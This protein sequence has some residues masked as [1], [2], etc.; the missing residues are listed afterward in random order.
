METLKFK[1]L[2]FGFKKQFLDRYNVDEILKE[3]HLTADLISEDVI[4]LIN[5]N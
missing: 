1:V 4:E 2:N 5:Y 3:N